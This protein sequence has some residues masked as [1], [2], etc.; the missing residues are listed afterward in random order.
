MCD[1]GAGDFSDWVY[2]VGASEIDLHDWDT[3]SLL[4]QCVLKRLLHPVRLRLNGIQ[5]YTRNG[6]FPFWQ[7]PMFKCIHRASVRRREH[8]GTC[9]AGGLESAT[10]SECCRIRND[11]ITDIAI[12]ERRHVSSFQITMMGLGNS[13]TASTGG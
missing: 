11:G 10:T 7:S 12:S 13:R 5:Q 9:P 8:L 6:Q 2:E 4:V 3:D 1:R